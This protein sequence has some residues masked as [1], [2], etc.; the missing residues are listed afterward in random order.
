MPNSVNALLNDKFSRE[1]YNA[2]L[3]ALKKIG[4]VKVEPKKTSVHLVNK[5][6]FAGVHPRKDYLILEIKSDHK[7]ASPRVKAEQISANRYHCAVRLE[8]AKD[9]DAEL[10]GWLKQAYALSA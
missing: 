10:L 6:G 4:P 7:I 8:S 5:T 2:L 1:T 3:T 9:V